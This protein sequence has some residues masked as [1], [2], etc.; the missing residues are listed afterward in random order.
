MGLLLAI[1]SSTLT[2]YVRSD[3]RL[4]DGVG[5][6]EYEG[7]LLLPSLLRL[8]FFVETERCLESLGY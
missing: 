1:A 7:R 4:L 2:K 6:T 3:M 8:C 5:L